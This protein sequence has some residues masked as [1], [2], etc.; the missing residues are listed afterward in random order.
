MGN[1]KSLRQLSLSNNR[2]RKLPPK[3]GGMISLEVLDLSCNKLITVPGS[4]C[5]LNNLLML[6]LAHNRIAELP[7]GLGQATSLQTLDLQDNVRPSTGV[8]SV[9]LRV[10]TLRVA[11][12]VTMLLAG[13]HRHSS[14]PWAAARHAVVQSAVQ[15]HHGAAA[16]DL[17]VS[18]SEVPGR[19]SQPLNPRM[20]DAKQDP[21]SSVVH[22]R[23]RCQV[24]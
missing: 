18:Q 19:V 3:I 23:A 8:V 4:F 9:R 17:R 22:W 6:N 16:G 10:M 7:D 2:L 14:N 15:R 21:A 5:Y 12:A 13:A 20:R 11:A 1:M 24:P